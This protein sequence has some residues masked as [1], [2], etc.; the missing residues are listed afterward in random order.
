MDG[1]DNDNSSTAFR[2]V[3]AEVPKAQESGWKSPTSAIPKEN[4]ILGDL[5]TEQNVSY[6]EG[7]LDIKGGLEG[8]RVGL[9]ENHQVR[10]SY[11]SFNLQ[12]AGPEFVVMSSEF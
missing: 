3:A 12:T 7:E 9:Q 5:K 2:N 1:D 4:N 10:K 11:S 6:F 8:V